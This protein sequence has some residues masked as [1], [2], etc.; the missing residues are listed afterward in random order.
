MYA[1]ASNAI[2]VSYRHRADRAAFDQFQQAISPTHY[3]VDGAE[4]RLRKRPRAE[5]F[6]RDLV[7]HYLQPQGTT[8]V[9]ASQASVH[10]QLVDWEIAAALTAQ[11]SLIVTPVPWI[12]AS[13]PLDAVCPPRALANVRSGY[14][15][16]RSWTDLLDSVAFS[17]TVAIARSQDRSLI[18]NDQRLKRR[19]GRPS[20]LRRLFDA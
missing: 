3:L 8:V 10:S 7:S 17:E 16:Q 11:H 2:F 14:A 6:V 4:V 12:D 9:L 13:L 19:D 1:G 18:R 20:F 15:L 5:D